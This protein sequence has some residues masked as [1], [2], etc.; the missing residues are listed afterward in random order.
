MA[1]KQIQITANAQGSPVVNIPDVT[2]WSPDGDQAQWN[3]TGPYEVYFPTESPF[4]NSSF[5]C[6]SGS[7]APLCSG[8]LNV[9]ATGDYKYN[10]R[11]GTKVLD[12]K[13]TVKP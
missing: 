6:P 10:V 13:V 12:P 3:G 11:I 1:I 7:S 4:S 8:P 5:N 2:L 9:G